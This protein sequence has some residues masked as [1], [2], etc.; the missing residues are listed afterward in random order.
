MCLIFSIQFLKI[1]FSNKNNSANIIYLR[2][3]SWVFSATFATYQL[4][5]HFVQIL[6]L[7]PPTDNFTNIRPVVPRRRTGMAK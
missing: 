7:K 4:K 6:Y 3:S 1:I 5:I 2:T